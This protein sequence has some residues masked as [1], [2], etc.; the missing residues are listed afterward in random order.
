MFSS[1]LGSAPDLAGE[2]GKHR[3]MQASKQVHFISP[4]EVELLCKGE[5]RSHWVRDMLGHSKAV[6][7]TGKT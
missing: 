3:G 2:I 1:T 7:G 6:W 4:G 5:V